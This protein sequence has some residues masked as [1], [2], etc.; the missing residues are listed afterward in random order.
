M[1]GSNETPPTFDESEWA[2]YEFKV[3]PED[4]DSFILNTIKPIVDDIEKE[5]HLN[6]FH[7]RRSN[8][9]ITLRV[10]ADTDIGT[11]IDEHNNRAPCAER[12][13]NWH[14]NDMNSGE[15]GARILIAERERLSRLAFE[16]LEADQKGVDIDVQ[17]FMGRQAHLSTNIYGAFIHFNN[18]IQNEEEFP[19]KI[20]CLFPERRE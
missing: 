3:E 17:Q 11:V 13:Q 1:S 7:F 15:Y 10:N 4:R 2:S 19:N 6:W 5:D 18:L 12:T 14:N 20:F 9:G 16:V 8:E